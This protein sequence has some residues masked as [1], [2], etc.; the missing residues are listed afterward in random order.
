[1]YAA[2]NFSYVT[3]ADFLAT[4]NEWSG[5]TKK[6]VSM[7]IGMK[8]DTPIGLFTLSLGYVFDLVF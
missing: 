1:M 8:V 7:D 2:A 6:P 5:R 3:K 4:E